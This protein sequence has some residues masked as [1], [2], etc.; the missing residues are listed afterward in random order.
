MPNSTSTP[1][2]G[3]ALAIAPYTSPSLMRRMRAPLAR[4]SSI[5]SAW[6]GR[7]RMTAVRSRTDSCFDFAIQRR[8]WVGLAVMSIAPTASGPTAILSM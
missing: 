8:F 3:Q 7:S 1:A 6:R 4:T 5:S 2:S